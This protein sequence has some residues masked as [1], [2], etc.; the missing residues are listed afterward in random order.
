VS[1]IFGV[2][3][4]TRSGAQWVQSSL[5]GG[6]VLSTLVSRRLGDFAVARLLAPE[7]VST[8]IASVLDDE[9]R[10]ILTSDV[11]L[12]TGRVLERFALAGV[13]TIVVEDDLARRGDAVLDHDLAYVEDRVVRWVNLLGDPVDGV[14]LLRSGASGYPLNAYAC[15]LS[16]GEL[17][18]ESGRNLEER[19]RESIVASTCAVLVSVFDG[20]AFVTLMSP[21]L[22]KCLA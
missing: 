14:R 20:E 17:G 3:I 9:S 8:G 16:P 12:L 7:V 2:P 4:D 6:S 18:L 21:E 11:N 1:D 5:T 10:G 19:E 15:W 13:R 22:G